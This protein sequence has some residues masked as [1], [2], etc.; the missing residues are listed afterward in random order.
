M[1]YIFFGSSEFAKII[2]KEL[3]QSGMKP[4]LVVTTP[5]KQKGRKKILS[6]TP[7]HS[8]AEQ[9][10]ISVLF[11]ENLESKEF[12]AEMSDCKPDL[13]ILTAYGK[14]IPSQLLSIP[15]KGFLNLHPSL[16]PRWRGATPIQSTILAGDK[17]TGVTLF[18]MD[19]QIDHG[20]TLKNKKLNIKDKRY[21]YSELMSELAEMGANLLIET[22]PK[23]LKGEITLK[24]QDEDLATYCHKITS[25][26]E[27][28]N[29]QT[30]AEE[31][32][33]K[34]RALNPNPGVYFECSEGSYFERSEKKGSERSEGSYF[35]RSEKKGSERSEGSYTLIN[36]KI[37]KI[38][39][40]F[41]VLA[42][43]IAS[44]KQ[45]GEIFEYL[46]QGK[47]QVAIKCKEGFY[48]IEELRPAGK[49][50]MTSESFI[51]GNKWILNQ[52]FNSDI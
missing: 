14:I 38:I 15:K 50:T 7:V 29:W 8:L 13:V 44:G 11:P 34:V 23:W 45:T 30:S 33:R 20:P 40:G 48:V 35:E 39:K 16:L 25:E 43:N 47:K 32:D 6:P 2:L 41:P 1:R 18:L 46:N 49:K 4:I 24:I 26:D 22:F 10:G 52:V 17:E 5:P 21:I 51:R 37:I 9:N 27:K 36:N 3:L 12:I 19:K 31:I 28:I 42:S